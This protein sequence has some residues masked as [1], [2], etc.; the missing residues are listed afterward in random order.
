MTTKNI[1]QSLLEGR[2]LRPDIWRVR[3]IY[4]NHDGEIVDDQGRV[5]EIRNHFNYVEVTV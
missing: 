5:H 3:Y 2:R 1:M 4:L